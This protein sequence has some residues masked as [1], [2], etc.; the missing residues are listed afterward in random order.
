ML[1]SRPEQRKSAFSQPL[2]ANRHSAPGP[3]GL[4]TPQP[5]QHLP[6]HLVG[7]AEPDPVSGTGLTRWQN[8]A[9]SLV[10]TVW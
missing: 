9:I 6:G 5:D 8:T 3:R 7:P 1:R 10:L 4:L 2:E